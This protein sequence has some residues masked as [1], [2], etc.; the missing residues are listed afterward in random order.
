MKLPTEWYL[1]F[2]GKTTKSGECFTYTG[3]CKSKGYGVIGYLGKRWAAHRLS[4]TLAKH[5]IQSSEQ[6]VMHSCDNPPCINPA[7]LSLGTHH[8]N[9]QDMM[10]KNRGSIRFVDADTKG[11][12]RRMYSDG[13]TINDL[14]T[15]LGIPSRVIEFIV[16]Q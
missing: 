11:K 9:M 5:P 4:Y 15:Y 14:Y 3:R 1:V 13:Y 7:H 10:R 6:L 8:E 2:D 12:I 16:E